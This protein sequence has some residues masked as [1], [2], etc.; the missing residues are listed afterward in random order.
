VGRL[1]AEHR[2]VGWRGLQRTAACPG[3]QIRG[4]PYI[5]AQV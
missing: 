4:S 1:T 3:A 5:P 2:C